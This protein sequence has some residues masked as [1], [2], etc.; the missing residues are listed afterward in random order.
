MNAY[1]L[2]ENGKYQNRFNYSYLNIKIG[3]SYQ[4]IK[5]NNRIYKGNNIFKFFENFNDYIIN[6]IAK[7]NIDIF[8]IQ[9]LGEINKK[10]EKLFTDHFK[11]IKKIPKSEWENITKGKLK[12]DQN[13]NLIY[14]EYDDGYWVKIQYDKN[15]NKIYRE[16]SKGYWWKKQYDQNNN[17]IYKEDSNGLWEKRQFDK[18]NNEIYYEN[19]NGL[20]FESKYDQ[21]NNLTFWGKKQFDQNNNE[22]YK[23]DS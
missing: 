9:I 19:S 23:E 12:F 15:N 2:T 16:Y 6:K 10:N 8:Q 18:N 17:E 13:N 7:K 3:Y 5:N 21:N 14:Y 22:I 20:C 11:I 4:I 1:I